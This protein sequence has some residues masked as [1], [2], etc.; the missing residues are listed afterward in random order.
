MGVLSSFK[1]SEVILKYGNILPYRARGYV[2]GDDFAREVVTPTGFPTLYTAAETGAAGSTG[3]DST[4]NRLNMLTDANIGDD[5]TVRTSGLRIDRN[6][7]S[8][9]TGMTQIDMQTSQVQIDLP[10]QC[11]AATDIE[12][13]VGIHVGVAALTALPTTARHMG[14]YWDISAGAN[15]TMTSGNNSAQVTT[16]TTIP[17]DTAVHI[18]RIIWTAEDVATLQLYSVAGATQGTGQTVAAFNGASGVSH[19]IVWFVQTEATA[20]K[21]LRAY[22]WRVAWT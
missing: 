5:Q 10:F 19:E 4:M 9:V 6:Y 2:F 3:I 17:V 13:F 12:G 15:F 11:S 7:N 20:A 22:P 1:T 18:M 16:D 14:V 21:T 8:L